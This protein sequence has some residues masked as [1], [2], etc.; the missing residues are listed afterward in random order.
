MDWHLIYGFLIVLA[1]FLV[2][3]FAFVV[4]SEKRDHER[5]LALIRKRLAEREQ[6]KKLSPRNTEDQDGA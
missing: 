3:W 1:L 6:Q 2:V 5:K 4:P